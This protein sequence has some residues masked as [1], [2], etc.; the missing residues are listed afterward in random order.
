[1][2][3]VHLAVDSKGHTKRDGK[4][5]SLEQRNEE[6]LLIPPNQATN[7]FLAIAAEHVHLLEDLYS[8][9]RYNIFV[10]SEDSTIDVPFENMTIA[11]TIEDV[12]EAEATMSNYL[13]VIG[14]KDFTDKFLPSAKYVKLLELDR[15]VEAGSEIITLDEIKSKTVVSSMK[16]M[17]AI[18]GDTGCEV[19]LYRL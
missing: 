9:E 6:A 15:E 16:A 19:N 10:V 7:H 1:M 12:I 18:Y 11:K 14:D 17:Q 2:I 4:P 5:I 3:L 8:D 13:Q